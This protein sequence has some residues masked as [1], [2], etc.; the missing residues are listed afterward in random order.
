MA[1]LITTPI[2]TSDQSTSPWGAEGVFMEHTIGTAGASHQRRN[3]GPSC[4]KRAA[5][6]RRAEAPRAGTV[7]GSNGGRSACGV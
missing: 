7:C 2:A 4:G 3:H 1:T 5:V 6:G